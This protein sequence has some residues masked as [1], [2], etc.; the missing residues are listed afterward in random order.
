M[1]QKFLSV[2]LTALMAT[3]LL[4]ACGG[5]KDAETSAPATEAASTSEAVPAETTD[6]APA[7]ETATEEAVNEDMVSDETFAAL[8]DTYS[9]LVDYH[10]AVVD[11][12]SSDEIA[13]DA[14]IEEV[15]NEA[16][17]LINQMGE[18]SQEELTEEDAMTL[19]DAMGDLVDALTYLVDGMEVADTAD[20]EMVS[21]ETFATL[22]ENYSILT[23]TYNAVADAYNSD[24]VEANADIE[25]TLNEAAGLIEQMGEIEQE[26]ITEEDAVELNN[27]MIAILE[28]LDTVVDAM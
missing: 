8:Q 20:V 26:S 23:E 27:A 3:T 6:S 28:V 22:Q 12:Y 5:S 25:D 15:I 19:N 7:E 13:A 10:N 24:S 11:L 17:D 9:A 1:K 4:T 14:E 16:A 2:I 18:I 21:N